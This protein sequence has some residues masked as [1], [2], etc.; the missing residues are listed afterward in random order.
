MKRRNYGRVL[1]ALVI[2][3]GLAGIASAQELFFET[4][5]STPWMLADQNNTTYLKI[6]LTGFDIGERRERTP[7]NVAIVLDRS[8]SP[9]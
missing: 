7:V 5:V 9:F 1:L 4:S 2:T 3:C 6:S 8:A